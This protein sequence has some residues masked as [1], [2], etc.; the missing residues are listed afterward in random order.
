MVEIKKNPKADLTRTS[1]MFLN[2]G[3]VVSLLLCILAFE[4][5]QFDDSNQLALQAGGE[6]FEEMM[7]SVFYRIKKMSKK[8]GY[9]GSK[10]K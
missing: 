1:G 7:N 3:L 10:D 6:N 2:L 4:W 5:K 9:N 8:S